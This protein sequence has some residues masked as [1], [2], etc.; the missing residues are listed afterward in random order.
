VRTTAA[1]CEQLRRRGG[2]ADTSGAAA[3]APMH[4]GWPSVCVRASFAVPR[5]NSM[6][7]PAVFDPPVLMTVA[8]HVLSVLVV[9][10]TS[11]TKPAA[12]ACVRHLLPCGRAWLWH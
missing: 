7:P 10:T 4:R 6:P 5:V 8:A 11:D 12:F 2:D 3:V 1:P 9:L